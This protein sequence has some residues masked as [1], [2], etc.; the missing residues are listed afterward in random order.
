MCRWVYYALL[1][2]PQRQ[3]PGHARS[4]DSLSTSCDYSVDSE[5]AAFLPQA[6][7]P[8]ANSDSRP[9]E[10]GVASAHGD[11]C[12][13]S[14]QWLQCFGCMR[15][16]LSTVVLT[17]VSWT[18]CFSTAADKASKPHLMSYQRRLSMTLGLYHYI[19]PLVIVY[20]AEY[21][22]QVKETPHNQHNGHRM[23][24]GS[25]GSK[26]LSVYSCSL[27]AGTW[28]AIGFPISDADARHRFYSYANW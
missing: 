14:S 15:K 8:T 17:L 10:A 22:M 28:A 13:R 5:A 20:A 18:A 27:Q 11:H 6:M 26:E 21:A 3:T 19:G 24:Q 2:K 25:Q 16:G 12:M 1:Q 7:A 9:T 4:S 23:L